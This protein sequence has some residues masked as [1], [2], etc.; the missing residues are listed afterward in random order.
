MK[1]DSFISELTKFIPIINNKENTLSEQKKK[2]LVIVG[3]LLIMAAIPATV[4][5]T[6]Q[7]RDYR[8]K[9][10]GPVSVEAESASLSGAVISGT[11]TTASGGSFIQFGTSSPGA[12]AVIVAVGDIACGADSTGAACKEKATSDLVAPI[13]PAAVLVLGDNQ[14]EQGQLAYYQGT[15][16]YCNSNPPRCYNAT[17]GRFKD[18]TWPVVGN[19][20]YLTA[21]ASGHFDYFNGVGVQTGRAG[22][23]SKGY[24]SVD[25]GSW[26]IVVLNSNCTPAGGCGATSPQATWLR[27][28]LAAHTNTCTLAAIHQPLYTSGGRSSTSIAPLWQ[29]LYD[30]NAE[31]VLVGHDHSYERFAPQDAGGN[32]DTARGLREFVVGTGG[33]NHTPLV[34]TVANSEI[35]DATSFGIMKLTLKPTSYDWQFIPIPGSSFTDSG[36]QNCH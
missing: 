15:D 31:M 7:L 8:S 21:G 11:D 6:I 2:Y 24:F 9:A 28:D 12:S 25:V 16:P 22:D 35:F 17:W 32:L 4:F 33:R 3:T 13:N 5:L 23:R 29:I 20:E 18:I 36:T 27:A 34:A 1:I 10:A 30:N 19:H 14:Y 26:H